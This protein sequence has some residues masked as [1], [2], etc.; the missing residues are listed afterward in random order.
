MHIEALE[1]RTLLTV[2]LTNGLLS[3][4]GTNA[5]DQI[6]VSRSKTGKVTVTEKTILVSGNQTIIT[7]LGSKTFAASAISWVIVRTGIGNDTV[8]LTGGATSPYT[9]P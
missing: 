4:L 5:N 3:I 1:G 6:N 9:Y 7:N 2:T 8:T